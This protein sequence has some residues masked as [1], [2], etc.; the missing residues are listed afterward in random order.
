LNLQNNCF[1]VPEKNE[2]YKDLIEQFY[3]SF[4]NLNA[5]GIA[6]CYHNKIHFMGSS[7]GID[8]VE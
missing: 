3:S 7:F 5:E 8:M 6:R 2:V 1:A 4:D